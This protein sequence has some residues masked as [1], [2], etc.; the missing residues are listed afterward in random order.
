MFDKLRAVRRENNVSA[1][2]MATLLGLATKAAYYKKETA[3]TRI[4]LKEAKLISDYFHIPI[5]ELFFANEVSEK[6]TSENDQINKVA[7]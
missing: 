3:A 1:R 6:E 7:Q 2:T 5:G 4:T